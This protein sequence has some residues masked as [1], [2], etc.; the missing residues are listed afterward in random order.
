MKFTGLNQDL[1]SIKLNTNPEGKERPSIKMPKIRLNTKI[2]E[3][4]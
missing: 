4:L 1:S 3:N 2:K